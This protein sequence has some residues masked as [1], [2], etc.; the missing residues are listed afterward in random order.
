MFRNDMKKSSI[1]ALKMTPSVPSLKPMSLT[2]PK[3]V[4][5]L[6][7][8][9]IPTISNVS[10]IDSLPMRHNVPLGPKTS[11]YSTNVDSVKAKKTLEQNYKQVMVDNRNTKKL[12]TGKYFIQGFLSIN[13]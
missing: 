2:T 1:V 12:K 3:S 9:Q 6:S 5:K 7:L 8:N 10:Y 13:I 11:I 4:Q